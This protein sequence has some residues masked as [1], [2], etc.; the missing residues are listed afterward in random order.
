M[1][2]RI[3]ENHSETTEED[4]QRFVKPF[5]KG[6]S[7]IYPD[8]EVAEEI[9]HPAGIKGFWPGYEYRYGYRY[10]NQYLCGY[11]KYAQHTSEV[12]KKATDDDLCNASKFITES[13][14][15]KLATRYLGLTSQQIEGRDAF[16]VLKL[17]RDA[18]PYQGSK[19]VTF[20]YLPS[21][22]CI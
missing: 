16:S 13:N 15:S 8:S 11:G 2:T 19:E 21:F 14:I 1:T 18:M 4:F 7:V 10:A 3:G 5:P 6:I 20:S 9:A 17:W 22:S 12:F